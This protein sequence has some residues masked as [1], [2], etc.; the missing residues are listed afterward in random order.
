MKHV[1]IAIGPD[2]YHNHI[3][4]LVITNSEHGNV[5]SKMDEY[6][7][8]NKLKMAECSLVAQEGKGKSDLWKTFDL[9]VET[10]GDKGGKKRV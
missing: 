6:E 10:T 1:C 9:V 4:T 5:D 7:V 3:N 2:I 8:K